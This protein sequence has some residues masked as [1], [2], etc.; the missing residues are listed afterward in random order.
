[1]TGTKAGLYGHFV[2]STAGKPALRQVEG[3]PGVDEPEI[4]G[5]AEHWHLEAEVPPAARHSLVTLLVP[6]PLDAP[7]RVL[8]FIDD[9]GFSWDLYCVDEDDREFSLVVPKDF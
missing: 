9:Q 2:L 7:R 1:V 8:H 5:L 6:Y 3:F 4:R